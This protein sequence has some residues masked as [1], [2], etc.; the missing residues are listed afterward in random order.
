MNY[1]SRNYYIIG[2]SISFLFLAIFIFL[3]EVYP[4]FLHSI[5]QEDGLIENLTAIFFG[6]SSFAFTIFAYRSAFLKEKTRLG[7]FMVISWILL[8]FVFAGEEI[9]WGQR[10]FDIE[11]PS[12]LKEINLQE[13]INIHNIEIVDTFLGGKYRYLSIMM[14][15]TGLFLPLFSL[16][17]IGKR[18][19]Q[20]LAF[21][22]SPLCFAP[23]FVGAYL[24]GKYYHPIIANDAAE[25]REFLM[26]V[27]ML[28]FAVTGAMCPCTLFRV[29]KPSRKLEVQQN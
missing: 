13:E 3:Q 4:D 19:I 2:A 28:C 5:V 21:P 24:S 15:V 14:L 23:L 10:I 20:K 12:A 11:T 17:E 16:S 18:S 22:V 26:S 7:Y 1:C 6:L 27:G 8:M 29:C 9:S 25:V